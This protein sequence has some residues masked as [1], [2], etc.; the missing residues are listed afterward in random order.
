M[1]LTRRPCGSGWKLSC[2]ATSNSSLSVSTWMTPDWWNISSTAA[3]GSWVARTVCPSGMPWEDRP[4]FTATIGL[5]REVRRAI[6]LNLRGL[7]M[8]SRYSSSTSVAGSSSQYWIR[9]LP[10]TSARLPAETKVDSPRPRDTIVSSSATPSA[11]DW[12]KKPIRPRPGITGDSDALSDTA[13]SVLS[14]PRQFGPITRIPLAR[15]RVTRVRCSC[16]PAPPTSANPDETTTRPSTP[17][18]AQSSATSRTAAGG[19]ATSARSTSPGMSLTR[20]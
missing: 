3:G 4:D 6:R 5:D 1:M 12:L 13:G 19:T 18:A 16:R 14:T 7:P 17:F 20:A 8:D 15:A 11:P 2:I 10:L 9:S